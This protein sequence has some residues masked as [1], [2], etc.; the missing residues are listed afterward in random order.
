P[1]VT[2]VPT[3]LEAHEG[4]GGH[5]AARQSVL[6]RSVIASYTRPTPIEIPILA[7]LMVERPLQKP[8]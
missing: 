4:V 5:A 8:A 7:R 1:T 2:A 6:A 3:A